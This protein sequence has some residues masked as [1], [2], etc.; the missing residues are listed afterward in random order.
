MQ[1]IIETD[2]E[3]LMKELGD[4]FTFKLDD[5]ILEDLCESL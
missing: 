1:F 3:I 4:E 5:R 2:E